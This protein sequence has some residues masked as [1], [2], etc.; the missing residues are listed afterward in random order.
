M[1]AEEKH[2]INTLLENLKHV[3]GESIKRDKKAEKLLSD[4][5][6]QIPGSQYYMAQTIIAQQELIRRL[7]DMVEKLSDS[8]NSV[9][10]TS[11][12]DE[13]E[14]NPSGFLKTAAETAATV[15]G[16][17]VFTKVIATVADD[18][19][20]SEEESFD[21][22]VDDDP[23]SGIDDSENDGYTNSPFGDDSDF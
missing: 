7:Q 8:G 13:E 17:A 20:F 9:T 23:Y 16:A 12:R 1:T 4:G 2:L 3:E 10:F 21:D 19:G 15:A 14:D 5:A 11:L 6:K 18:L 22:F